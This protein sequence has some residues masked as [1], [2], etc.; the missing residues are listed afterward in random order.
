M[1]CAVSDFAYFSL[2]MERLRGAAGI[3]LL[4]CLRE[5]RSKVRGLVSYLYVAGLDLGGAGLEEN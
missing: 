3:F 1:G 5:L 4:S 2:Y